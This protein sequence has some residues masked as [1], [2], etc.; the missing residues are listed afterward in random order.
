VLVRSA[1]NDGWCWKRVAPLLRAVGHEVYALT[2]T[3]LSERVQ[4]AL[5][6]VGLDRQLAVGH[7]QPCRAWA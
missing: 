3:G 7:V 1:W 4:L 5:P 2:L 6:E